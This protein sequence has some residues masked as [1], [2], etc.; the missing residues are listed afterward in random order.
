MRKR[1]M[2][3]AV[4][5]LLA[6]AV[7]L[8]GF[9]AM[10]QSQQTLQGRGMAPN[11][12]ISPYTYYICYVK[13]QLNR[14]TDGTLSYKLRMDT[15]QAVSLGYCNVRLQRYTSNGWTDEINGRYYEARNTNYFSFSDTI[16]NLPAGQYRVAV[17]YNV[18]NN[19]YTDYV[20]DVSEYEYL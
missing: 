4:A 6:V 8:C 17:D 15:T 19:G 12:D 7:S 16:Y 9:S 11:G 1:N 18:S 10:A 13:T 14:V 5:V 20:Y 2:V 3:R